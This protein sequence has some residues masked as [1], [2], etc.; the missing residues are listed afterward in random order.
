RPVNRE[1]V[2]RL[3]ARNLTGLKEI[4]PLDVDGVRPFDYLPPR[5]RRIIEGADA[6]HVKGAN[7]FETCQIPGKETCHAFTVYG[8]ISRTYTGLRDFDA[9][10]AH[11]PAGT[12]G[13]AHHREPDQI[14]TL[15][16]VVRRRDA[17]ATRHA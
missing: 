14:V 1:G 7:Y 8:P 13:Y 6:A 17:E 4:G 16:D 10:F 5:A 11:L 9:V 3:L 2:E 15:R 12:A